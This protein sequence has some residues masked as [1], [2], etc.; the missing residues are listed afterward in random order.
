MVDRVS[1][2]CVLRFLYVLVI[3]R[4]SSFEEIGVF[5]QRTKLDSIPDLRLFFF[6]KVDTLRVAT[7]FKIEDRIA[8]PTVLIITN[9]FSF[10]ISRKSGF[11]STR[12]TEEN[13]SITV[14]SNVGRAMHGKH[15]L[16]MWKNEIQNG[17]NSFFDLSC[18]SST[19]NKNHLLSEVQNCKVMLTGSVNFRIGIETRSANDPPLWVKIQYFF[20]GRTQEQVVREKVGPRKLCC[21]TDIHSVLFV[22]AYVRVAHVHLFVL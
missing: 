16:L 22:S 6:G 19:T 10:R 1:N 14:F 12:K 2:S 17:E 7:T 4:R 18:V 8:I 3:N 9:K 20:F 5:N 15:I 13:G 21:N 11:S